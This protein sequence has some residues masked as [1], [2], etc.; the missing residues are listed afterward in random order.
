MRVTNLTEVSEFLLAAK[1]TRAA[2]YERPFGVC[3]PDLTTVAHCSSIAAGSDVYFWLPSLPDSTEAASCPIDNSYFFPEKRI[4][5]SDVVPSS[6]FRVT[7]AESRS[8]R[9]NST[10]R[11]GTVAITLLDLMM[12][13]STLGP[14]PSHL[15]W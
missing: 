12:F 10:K 5:V 1:I 6:A 7:D 8:G 13:N 4:S 14:V 11:A 2:R 15:T 9:L 3:C